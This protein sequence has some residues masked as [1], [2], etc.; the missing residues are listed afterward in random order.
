MI[1]PTGRKEI[2]EAVVIAALCILA[3]GLVNWG[4]ETAKTQMAERKKRRE[5]ETAEQALERKAKEAV[6]VARQCAREAAQQETEPMTHAEMQLA[7]KAA[8]KV[9]ANKDELQHCAQTRFPLSASTCKRA[10]LKSVDQAFDAEQAAVQIRARASEMRRT[11]QEMH[12]QADALG[13]TARTLREQAD[14][15]RAMG[16]Q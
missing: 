12:N 3:T 14:Q 16:C 2:K 10:Y 4:I 15:Y 1:Q 6:E 7:E 8:M 5:T 9:A 13:E 11:F